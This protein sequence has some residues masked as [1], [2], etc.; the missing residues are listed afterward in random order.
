MEISIARVCNLSAGLAD[1]EK[2]LPLN[3]HVHRII[4]CRK[5]ALR[6]NDFRG[7]RF[8]SQSNLQALGNFGC[9]VLEALPADILILQ[10]LKWAFRAL[11]AGVDIGKIVG[12]RVNV[13]LLRFH[14][15]CR[16]M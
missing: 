8:G 2:A 4:G 7:D 1:L 16:G 12:N 3:N 14:S 15:A 13:Q 6:E 5:I 11:N 10:I 9:A